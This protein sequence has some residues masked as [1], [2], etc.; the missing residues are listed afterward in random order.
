MS[1]RKSKPAKMLEVEGK[2]LKT[3][4]WTLY[5][6]T[7]ENFGLLAVEDLQKSQTS[8]IFESSSLLIYFCFLQGLVGF[9]WQ[10]IEVRSKLKRIISSDWWS[11]CQLWY[12]FRSVMYPNFWRLIFSFHLEVRGNW[13]MVILV[14]RVQTKIQT[15]N[16][17]ILRDKKKLASVWRVVNEKKFATP[18]VISPVRPIIL[19]RLSFIL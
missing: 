1:S 17:T 2:L 5:D 8:N 13:W 11:W 4:T 7:M 18:S 16:S 15:S 12:C 19:C 10:Y 3:L 9:H 6:I 14:S